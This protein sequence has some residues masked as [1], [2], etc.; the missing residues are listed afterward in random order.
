MPVEHAGVYFD[1]AK[2]HA[3]WL[4]TA[5][6]IVRW[7]GASQLWCECGPAS[8]RQWANQRRMLVVSGWLFTTSRQRCAATPAF[9]TTRLVRSYDAQ[10]ADQLA[11]ISYSSAATVSGLSARRYPHALN[12]FGFVCLRLRSVRSL[13]ARSPASNI[14]AVP[15]RGMSYCARL[16]S[17]RCKPRCVILMTLKWKE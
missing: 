14:L 15:Q 16:S 6:S 4:I 12:G 8:A 11:D 10:L 17:A 1:S 5:W 7:R 2:R 13:L 3:T 9:Q